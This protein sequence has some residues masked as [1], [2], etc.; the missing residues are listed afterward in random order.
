MRKAAMEKMIGTNK[1]CSWRGEEERG[2]SVQ[3]YLRDKVYSLSK[4]EN[5][6]NTEQGGPHGIKVKNPL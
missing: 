2:P 6:G 5:G 1:W 3:S 4:D